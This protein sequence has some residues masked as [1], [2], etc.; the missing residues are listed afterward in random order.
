MDKVPT[1][2]ACG[3]VP[4]VVKQL[5]HEVARQRGTTLSALV[6]EAVEAE[7]RTEFG[8]TTADRLQA[9]EAEDED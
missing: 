6:R 7:V 4:V 9:E 8:L 1:T 3:N 2:T 5:A